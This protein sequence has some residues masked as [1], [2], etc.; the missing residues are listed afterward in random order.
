M[1]NVITLE[2]ID[3]ALSNLPYRNRNSLKCRLLAAIR[4]FYVEEGSP[5]GVGRID[6][7]ALIRRLW[8][9]GEDPKK[10]RARRKNLSTAR[11]SINKDL[12]AL[13]GEGKNPEGIVIGEQN[14]FVMSDEAKDS[15]LD[16]FR[17]RMDVGGPRSL[18]DVT[19]A[20]QLVTEMLADPKIMEGLGPGDHLGKLERVRE[21]IQALSQQL[22]TVGPEGEAVAG[23]VGPA[24]GEGETTVGLPD[25]AL[26]VAEMLGD[27]EFEVVELSEGEEGPE[28]FPGLEEEGEA[29]ADAQGIGD[30][31][32][33]LEEELPAEGEE[34][35]GELEEVD[36]SGDEAPLEEEVVEEVPEEDLAGE[37]AGADEVVEELD[38]E[39]LA[40]EG[41][42]E[43]A[44]VPEGEEGDLEEVLLAEGEEGLEA[45]PGL[46]EEGE[47]EADAEG[48]GD[49]EEELEEELPAEAEEEDGELEEVDLSGDEAPLEE[50]AVEDVPIE[51]GQDQAGPD[52]AEIGSDYLDPEEESHKGQNARLLAEQFERFLSE[53]ERFFN[54]YIEIPGGDYLVGSKQPRNHELEARAVRLGR[55]YL[56]KFPVINA[57]FE[58]F[59][60][61]T[62]YKTIAERRGYG[63]VYSG[64]FRKV[65][66]E[67]T[68]QVSFVF[69]KGLGY[70]KVAGASWYQ[71]D[72]PGSTLHLKR[73]HP[74]VQ[75]T[76]EDAMAF[77]AWVGKR[78]P[79][80]E[81]WEAA[82][83]TPIGNA[84]PWGNEWRKDACN[85]EESQVAGTT[86]VEQYEA[87]ANDF[88]IVDGLGNVL[89]WTLD[90][91]DPP[92]YG[93]SHQRHH[94]A[95]GGSWISASDVRLHS[96]FKF[97][98]DTAS[99]ILGFRCL[100]D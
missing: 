71:P 99:N 1:A 94:I 37:E 49:G 68:G 97:A 3:T 59:V 89:E 86:S 98:A 79:R 82:M 95:K 9:T 77:A 91:C 88:G 46:E 21:A 22:G 36:L 80:E 44:A 74:V 13:Y 66:N 50:E 29:E 23:T 83:R 55:C 20:L 54:Q 11:R 2:G 10:I 12:E 61:E 67:R 62:G 14:T 4:S 38:E 26:R 6:G 8:D 18:E 90:E 51:E 100:A 30:G 7:D 93:R 41:E 42:E 34:E 70:E 53:R 16:S 52:I 64:R 28:A 63:L 27:E 48:I 69:N 31:E 47:V 72:G 32:E 17:D 92:P 87:F 43:D 15:V 84:L 81:E 45:F 33:E 85:V 75:V 19:D 39:A 65:V 57:L 60:E 73:N 96:R 24:E 40:V 5:A 58:V 25:S 56:G 76:L 35:D 78:L